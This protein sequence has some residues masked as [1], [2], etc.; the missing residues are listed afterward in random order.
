MGR[1]GT[2]RDGTGRDGT[3]RDGTG[4]DG[5]G[6]DGMGWDR[7]DVTR[8]DRTGWTG[9]RQGSGYWADCSEQEELPECRLATFPCVVR[10]C[11]QI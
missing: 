9:S 8:R 4:R 10:T 3:G 5:M 2:G 6:W 7:K 1:D 11:L